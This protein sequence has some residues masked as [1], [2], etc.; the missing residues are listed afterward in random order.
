MSGGVISPL[1]DMS[2]CTNPA[3]ERKSFFYFNRSNMGLGDRDF[4]A[5]PRMLRATLGSPAPGS[6]LLNPHPS[7]PIL[8]SE[9]LSSASL[10]L[11]L[12]FFDRELDDSDIRAHPADSNG[13]QQDPEDLELFDEL[14]I[15]IARRRLELRAAQQSASRSFSGGALF[16]ESRNDSMVMRGPNV[17]S[18]PVAVGSEP[19]RS[20]IIGDANYASHKF[21]DEALFCESW[22]DSPVTRGPN[23]ASAPGEF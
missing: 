6:R 7:D 13:H 4:K 11:E 22:H 14:L 23:A 15:G 16:C 17:A 9:Q 3:N 18:A 20:D 5:D 2:S 1:T 21:C 19:S 10:S 12:P 8:E